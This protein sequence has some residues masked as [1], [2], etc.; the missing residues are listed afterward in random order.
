MQ[1]TWAY[2]A[3]IEGTAGEFVGSFPDVPEAITGGATRDE[4]EAN[5]VD[6]LSAAVEHYFFLGRPVPVPRAARKGELCIGLDPQLAARARLT[7]AMME[8]AIT[9]VAL[10]ARMHKDE[11][12][13]RRILSGRGATLDLTLEALRALGIRPALIA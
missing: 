6:A 10:A 9:K 4:V 11:K 1:T 3:V 13:V 8:G 2:P 7:Q 5:L 12:V